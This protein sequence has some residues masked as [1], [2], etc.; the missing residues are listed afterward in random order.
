MNEGA[1][2][3]NGAHGGQVVI[4]SGT[5]CATQLRLLDGI[6]LSKN[7]GMDVVPFTVDKSRR[8]I[9]R[10]ACNHGIVNEGKSRQ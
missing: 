7:L 4:N 6:L 10:G 3:G 9:V 5:N 1:G 8:H 2:L